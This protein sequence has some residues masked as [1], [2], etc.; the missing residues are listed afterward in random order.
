MFLISKPTSQ[1]TSIQLIPFPMDGEGGVIE[2]AFPMDYQLLNSPAS[3]GQ[4]REDH[5]V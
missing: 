1:L 3:T 2:S 5:Q 4:G